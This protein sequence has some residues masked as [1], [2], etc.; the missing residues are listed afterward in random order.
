[1]KWPAPQSPKPK[2]GNNMKTKL[3]T[4]TKSDD[5]AANARLI[6]AAPTLLKVAKM[7]LEEI[8]RNGELACAL[9]NAI[10]QAEG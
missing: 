6:A 9:S 8:A 5:K 2:V 10:N 1:M 7:A 3:G 4:P